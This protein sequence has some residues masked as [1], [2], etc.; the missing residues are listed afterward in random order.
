MAADLLAQAD[1]YIQFAEECVNNI[2]GSIF[3]IVSVGTEIASAI[4]GII[5]LI[6]N[7]GNIADMGELFDSNGYVNANI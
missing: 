1:K 3:E 7:V 2:F 6:K 4:K 5:D